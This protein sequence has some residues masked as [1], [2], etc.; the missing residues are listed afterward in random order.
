MADTNTTF[1][2]TMNFGTNLQP[3]VVDASTPRGTIGAAN[4]HWKQVYS[5]QYNLKA[6]AHLIYNDS[7]DSIDFVFDS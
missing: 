1:E 4:N 6:K 5:E 2:K 3:I 7:D